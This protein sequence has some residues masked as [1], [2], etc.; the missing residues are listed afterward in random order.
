[1]RIA[2]VGAGLTGLSAAGFLS[3]DPR[4][5]TTVFETRARFGGQVDG[6]HVA[7][8][9]D[10]LSRLGVTLRCIAQVE[11]LAVD[12]SGAD[13][14]INGLAERFDVALVT[15]S[16]VEA[17][18][19][20]ARSGIGR[21]A[22]SGP[23][24]ERVYFTEYDSADAKESARSGLERI[25]ADHPTVR[26]RPCSWMLPDAAPREPRVA[27]TLRSLARRVGRHVDYLD[28][29]GEHWPLDAPAVYIANQR[30][31]LDVAVPQRLATTPTTCATNAARLEAGLSLAFVVAPAPDCAT[32]GSPFR[33]AALAALTA[34]APIVPIA[35]QQRPAPASRL[36]LGRAQ[37]LPRVVV[38][39]PFYPE[40]SSVDELM[41]DMQAVMRHLERIP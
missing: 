29:S 17:C 6:H 36:A 27:R 38:G 5:V 24:R 39:E 1:M 31:V 28:L 30:W 11:R 16:V 32:D 18:A 40:T 8:C 25:A 20:L 26:P 35:A 3:E 13:L 23:L 4:H 41:D 22:R 2:I 21:P 7:D 34:N 10:H 15:T 33:A 19:L 14:W 12:D 9:V 37:P